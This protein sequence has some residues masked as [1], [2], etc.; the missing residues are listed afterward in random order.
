MPGKVGQSK[1]MAKYGA[2]L[3]QAVLAHKDDPI[4]Y[5][6]RRL[7]GGLQG[8]AQL[9]KCEFGEVEQGK[10]KAGQ[11]YW[12]AEGVVVECNK[13][14][15]VG[16]S[17]SIIRTLDEYQTSGAGRN[18]ARTV[19][20]EENVAWVQNQLKMLAGEGAVVDDLEQ[21]CEQLVAAAPYFKFSTT[22]APVTPQNPDPRVFEN[23]HGSK[24]LESYVP[25]GG[26]THNDATASAPV[27]TVHG[28]ASGNGRTTNKAAAAPS[29]AKPATAAK[30]TTTARAPTK[31]AAKPAPAPKAPE[32]EPEVEY[33]DSEDI[34]S[35]MERAKADPPDAEACAKL[36][37]M[38]IEA[39]HDAETVQALDSWDDVRAL[40]EE[41]A[42]AEGEAAEGDSGWEIGG[43]YGFKAPDPRTK[44]PG[45]KIEVELLEFD[46]AKDTAKVRSPATKTVYN[47]K[48]SA[49][50]AAD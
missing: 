47:C 4:D 35:L 12:R 6:F 49:L 40:I 36:T 11:I 33:S 26:S 15:Y 28:P 13:P 31:P 8:V 34:D 16:D 32:P 18:P 37:A 42:E 38:A 7:P 23:W 46:A 22:S 43:I 30:P 10:D 20:F 17:T 41:P 45:K 2:K 21:M 44:R 48:L 3:Q 27:E 19:S 39:G 25:N 24:G 1:L 29:P 14:E 5:G 9:T 50:E